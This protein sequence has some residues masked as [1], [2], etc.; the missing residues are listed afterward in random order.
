MLKDYWRGPYLG[1]SKA[2]KEA[3]RI[4]RVPGYTPWRLATKN[5]FDTI[6]GKINKKNRIKS[7]ALSDICIIN[8]ATFQVENAGRSTDLYI[9]PVCEK[10]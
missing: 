8:T 3:E 2:K 7:I 1:Y 5:D 10:V 6:S 9:C 4:P